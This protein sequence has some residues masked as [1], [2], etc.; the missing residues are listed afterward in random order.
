MELVYLWV[1]DYKNIHQ[2]GFNFSGRYRCNYDTEKNELTI[3]E[4]KEYVHIFPDNINVTAIVGEN[5]SGKSSILEIIHNFIN[6]PLNQPFTILSPLMVIR[7]ANN[8]T[9]FNTFDIE[10]IITD[11]EYKALFVPKFYQEKFKD[12]YDHLKLFYCSLYDYGLNLSETYILN[13]NHPTLYPKKNVHMGLIQQ[14]DLHSLVY[15]LLDTTHK[16]YFN[17]YFSPDKI[18]LSENSSTRNNRS[19]LEESFSNLSMLKEILTTEIEYFIFI[20]YQYISNLILMLSPNKNYEFLKKIY[21]LNDYKRVLDEKI[22]NNVLTFQND[23]QKKWIID[24]I[25]Q[26]YEYFETIFQNSFVHQFLKIEPEFNADDKKVFNYKFILSASNESL[27]FLKNYPDC[28]EIDFK[29]TRKNFYYHSLSAG[30]KSIL[31]VRYYLENTIHQNPNQDSFIFLFDEMDNELHPDWQ[32]KVIK[33]L[34]DIFNKRAKNFHFIFN[35]HSPF[36]LSDIPKENVIFLKDGKEKKVDIDTFGANIHTLLSH[37]FFMKNGLMGEFAKEKINQAISY[38]NKKQLS[39][40]ELSYCE[41]IISII[42]EPILKQQLQKMLDSKR[43]SEVEHIK[44]QIEE[45][46]KQLSEYQHA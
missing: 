36:I 42:G 5:G 6:N 13:F 31:R 27:L 44:K 35:S 21:T 41:D 12:N 30:E 8:L 22:K 39:E 16:Q 20:G 38:L 26:A 37:G 18:F 40:D 45:L 4:N 3:D 46:T 28:F 32:K 33:Y 14:S 19:N 29:D 15:Y 17:D 34:L 43:L 23:D 9:I 10:K 2:Q 11:I 7:H 24:K 1:E 25:Q